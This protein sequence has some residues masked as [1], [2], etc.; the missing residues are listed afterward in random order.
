MTTFL[1]AKR[2]SLWLLI[3]TC[4]C[5][6]SAAPFKQPGAAE[7]PAN[8]PARLS[9]QAFGQLPLS[10]EANQGQA[11]EP[12]KFLARGPGYNLSLLA[13]EAVLHL[14]RVDGQFTSHQPAATLRLKL[15]GA[16]AAAR[17]VGEDALPG[18]SHYLIGGD[19]RGWRTDVPQFA[20]VKYEAV[21]PGVDLVYYGNQQELEYDFIVAPGAD[22]RAIRLRFAGAQGLTLAPNGDL[23]LSTEAGT[24]RQHA[25]VVYQ[26]VNGARR[27]V[28]G[29]YVIR[30]KGEVGFAL[31]AYDARLPLVIDPVLS[32]AT[33][34]GGPATA[35]FADMT[36]DKDGNVVLCGYVSS[37]NLPVTPGAF[38]PRLNNN[39]RIFDGFVMKLN[40]A[41]TQILFATYLGGTGGLG[42]DVC[43]SV[44]TDTEGNVYVAG[45]T[46]CL[47]FPFKNGFQSERRS[48]I[49]TDVVN[50]A[51]LVKLDP[52]GSQLLY[53][54]RFAD[55]T[56]AN[57]VGASGLA[58]AGTKA[59][60]TGRG[61]RK[62]DAPLY[63]RPSGYVL[64]VDTAKTGA[65]SKLFTR[66]FNGGFGTSVA[67]DA[68]GKVYCA[69]F[70]DGEF[71]R[72]TPAVGPQAH[73]VFAA[74]FDPDKPPA[75]ALV[76]ATSVGVTPLDPAS[77]VASR[78]DGLAVDERGQLYAAG[79][80][81]GAINTTANAFQTAPGSTCAG[82]FDGAVMKFGAQGELLYASYLGGNRRDG[83]ADLELL[84]A[85]R[86]AVVGLTYSDNFPVTADAPRRQ[87][88]GNS[89]AFITQLDLG[90][91]GNAALVYST[92]YG[93]NG[94]GLDSEGA[95]R[96]SKDSA[97]N[98]YVLGNTSSADF[99][100]TPNAL[101]GAR[102]HPAND[103]RLTHG[104]L[105]KLSGAFTPTLAAAN[106]SAA[107]Y[108]G[109]T[110]AADSI[111]AAFGAS[112]AMSTRVALAT[113]LPT[114]LAG[115]TITV[116]DGAGVERFAP[117]FFVSP[118]QVN[119]LIPSGSAPGAATVTID[120][121]SGARSTET[122]QIAAVAPGL[123]SV[124]ASGKGWAAAVALRVKAD[125]SRSFEPVAH[126]DAVQNRFVGVPIEF[127]P[128]GEEV[129][130]LLFGTGLRWRSSLNNLSVMAGGLSA[131]VSYAGAQ[132]LAGL[133]QINFRLPRALRGRGTVEVVLTADGKAANAVQIAIK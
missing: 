124:D 98:L 27:T 53:G 9:A 114:E 105:V 29:R 89:D 123:F 4:L 17:I 119:Y 100:V 75:S 31:G 91:T 55:D 101:Q 12:V 56:H 3:F 93:G 47:S 20:R 2:G 103:Y 120:S 54:T 94:A 6:V 32:Y 26:Q 28:A 97:G 118:T 76:Y 92:Y 65:A 7:R 16:N 133:D 39:E 127:G 67:V 117:L 69:G 44:Q 40:P 109:A 63:A 62:D 111:V 129:F 14:R 51:F 33:Y 82:C 108:A 107:S 19:P 42:I 81:T 60:L 34:L 11:A 72:T 116:R 99:P 106:V 113:P 45:Q 95:G 131:E 122:L 83:A 41:G 79:S 104:F 36:L 49:D 71:T 52:Q 115:T 87:L 18:R 25:P 88:N 50:N 24:V 102:L 80:V 58:V 15:A 13:D 10:F 8:E 23:L 126:F 1:N 128:E 78:L 66:V 21:Y 121:P 68:Q 30:G 5:A 112:L 86:L 48:G 38:Q 77:T 96:V 125:G 22:A 130:L 46:G 84:G 61:N 74:K 35:V 43:N 37:N 85:D 57:Q 90:K 64:I 132:G 73:S 110:L 59:Y 70:A